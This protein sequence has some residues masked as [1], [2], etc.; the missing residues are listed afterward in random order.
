MSKATPK[1]RKKMH[2]QNGKNYAMPRTNG[3]NP[4]E[5]RWALLTKKDNQWHWVALDITKEARIVTAAD[6]IEAFEAVNMEPTDQSSD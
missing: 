6:F 5:R 4:P 3:H 2:K 1:W